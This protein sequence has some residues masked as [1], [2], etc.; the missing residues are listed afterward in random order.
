MKCD[1]SD[2]CRRFRYVCYSD[3]I[4][5]DDA[6]CLTTILLVN[7]DL[8]FII[9]VVLSVAFPKRLVL[10]QHLLR[11]YQKKRCRVVLADPHIIYI[12]T[13]NRVSFIP[14]TLSI[15]ATETCDSIHL[16]AYDHTSGLFIQRIM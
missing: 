7:K 3:Q 6:R 1:L 2:A 9:I 16:K 13:E 5:F 15:T 10:R 12:N 11:H 4:V 14:H 8:R